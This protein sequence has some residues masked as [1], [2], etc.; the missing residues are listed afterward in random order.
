[1]IG[2]IV[3]GVVAFV[4]AVGAVVFVVEGVAA[5][6]VSSVGVINFA[7]VTWLVG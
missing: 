5:G 3:V 6:M 7:G 1:M 4:A 2:C